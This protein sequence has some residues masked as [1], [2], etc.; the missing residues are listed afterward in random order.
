MKTPKTDERATR[1]TD[2]FRSRG[3]MN[4]DLKCDGARLSL[5]VAP[6]ANPDDPGEWRVEAS[7]SQS[8]AVAPIIRWA[9]SRGD[10]VRDVGVA[11][12]A[13]GVLMGLPSFDWQAVAVALRAVRAI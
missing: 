11:W 2:Q 5:M 7:S 6:R 12:S 8:P 4:Y 3:G 1:I 10:A 9:A 13:E